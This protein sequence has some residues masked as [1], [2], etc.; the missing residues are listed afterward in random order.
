MKKVLVL[1]SGGIDSTVCLVLAI[2]KYKKENV[3]ALGI[4]Y[5]QKNDKE[6]LKAKEISKYYGVYYDEI[7]ISNILKVSSS[8]MLKTSNIDIPHISYDEQYKNLKEGEDVSTNV[9]FR[10]GLMLSVCT[11]YA[12]SKNI[13]EIYYG[14]HK[15]EGI[16]RSLYP[17][18]DED[19][20][21]AM[22]L[23][24]YIGSGKKVKINAPLSGMLKD[25]VIAL[26]LKLNIPLNLTWTCYEDK[27]IPCGKC[28][29]CTD[30]IKGF[31]K[32][33]MIDPLKYNGG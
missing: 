13:D 12:I 30:R 29:A 25:E 20:N 31:Q 32:N 23:A 9:P 2:K 4:Y 10:N 22:N 11:T 26:G 3:N 21:M 18:C 19:F 33:N 16:A 6:L 5:G 27:E 28:T 17:D 24:I 8:S 1:F 7:D 14:I 15:E